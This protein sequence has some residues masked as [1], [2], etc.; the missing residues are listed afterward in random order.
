MGVGVGVGDWEWER[1][2]ESKR[3]GHAREGRG[4]EETASERDRTMCQL[5]IE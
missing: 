3:Q 1:V 5:V 4:R 2:G